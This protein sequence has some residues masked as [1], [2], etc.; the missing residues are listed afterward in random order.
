MPVKSAR[1]LL[2][3]A[4]FLCGSF[5]VHAAPPNPNEVRAGLYYVHFSASADDI[6]G[7]YVPPG[8]N[9]RL[10]DL[11][12]LYVAY[13]RRLTTHFGIELTVGY[14]PLTKTEGRGPATLGSVPYNGQVISTARWLAPTLLGEYSFFDDSS[15]WRPYVGVGVNYTRFYSR[16]STTAGNAATGGPTSLSLP[17][18]VGP[19]AIVGVSYHPFERWSLNASYSTA[20][21][22]SKLTADTAGVIRTTHIDFWP[23]VLVLSAGYSF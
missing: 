11:E 7:P 8:V 17:V 20:V 3:V 10:Q 1:I 21:I 6:S 16:Q 18:S 19:A 2:F 22:R 12:T 15:R 14:P 5:S 23:R 4:I 13:I 9:L